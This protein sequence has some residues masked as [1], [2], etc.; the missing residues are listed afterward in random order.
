M[1]CPRCKSN[2]NPR[3][4]TNVNQV[5]EVDQCE[6]CKG[7]WFDESEL[8]QI[9]NISEPKIWEF[10]SIPSEYEQLTALY[11]PKCTGHPLMKK[12]EHSRDRKVILDY[13][14]NCNGIWLDH[15][16]LEAIQQ[17]NLLQFVWRFFS[18]LM[19]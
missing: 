19:K 7:I 6:N 12:S 10:R 15:G 18:N 3:Q 2:L 8:E 4:I 11:C 17:E 9:E 16:E 5:I 1:N 14:E 13:C